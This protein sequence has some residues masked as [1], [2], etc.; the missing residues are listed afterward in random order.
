MPFGR[1]S[2]TA[3]N[4]PPSA[5]SQ[6][7]GSAPVNQLFPALTE[8]APMIGPMMVPRPP[9]AVQITTSI[10]LAGSNSPG[11]MMPTCGTYSA[12]AIPAITAESVKA[13]S[14]TFAG[15]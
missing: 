3:T 15:L 7:S 2:V 14:F 6:Y 13:K 11:L 12:P 9:T 10:E 5:N 1:N 8:S 4:S